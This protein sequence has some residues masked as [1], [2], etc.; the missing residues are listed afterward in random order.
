MKVDTKE[1]IR[2][3][4]KIKQACR[5]T[6]PNTVLVHDTNDEFVTLTV[7]RREAQMI[8][9]FIKGHSIW[10]FVPTNDTII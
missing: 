6:Y 10:D 5:I 7:T 3:L 2:L 8:E 4:D 1:C 9:Q